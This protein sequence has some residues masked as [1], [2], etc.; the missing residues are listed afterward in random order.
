MAAE[1]ESRHA[2]KNGD[3]EAAQDR[4]REARRERT[5]A[6]KRLDELRKSLEAQGCIWPTDA[7]VDAMHKA[8][9][10]AIEGVI[11]SH[12]TLTGTKR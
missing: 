3:S 11:R 12:D 5:I 2:R 6:E 10:E 4:A 8:Q 9:G 1:R 7:Q